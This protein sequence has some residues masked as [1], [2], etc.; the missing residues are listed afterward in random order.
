MV[1]VISFV[2]RHNSG[3]TTVLIQVLEKLQLMGIK[4]AVIKHS[5][6][7]LTPDDSDSGK[8]FAAGAQQVYL[9]TPH[10]TLTYRREEEK[11]LETMIAEVRPPVDI[12]L[13]EGYKQ[14]SY[15]KVEVIRHDVD[16]EPLELTNVIARVTD[17]EFND[18]IL[19]F[20]FGEEAELV[21]Y[22]MKQS[23]KPAEKDPGGAANA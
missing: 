4:S 5:H 15:P 6:H 2:G 17:C 9:S 16:P 23:R 21:R 20:G 18:G 10:E 12:V 8:L 13:L 3:K 7:M 1:P 22:L 14:S 19:Q 11:S